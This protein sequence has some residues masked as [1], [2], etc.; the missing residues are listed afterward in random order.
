MHCDFKEKSAIML[1]NVQTKAVLIPEGTIVGHYKKV[2]AVYDFDENDELPE[3]VVNLISKKRKK[4][5]RPSH[6]KFHKH[7][8]MF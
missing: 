4:C 2:L 3:K 1:M 5:S 7:K 8:Q 6:I